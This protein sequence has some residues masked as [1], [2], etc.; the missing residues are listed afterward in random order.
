M[1]IPKLIK[2]GNKTILT[3]KDKT[4]VALAGEVHNSD[5]S[6]VEYMEGIWKIADDL[7]MNTLLLPVTWE[8]VEPV[9]GQYDFKIVED[10]I[11]QAR[12]WGKKIGFLW[13][14]SWKNAECMYTPEWVKTDLARFK[15][16]Q[17]EKGKNKAGRQISPSIPFKMPYTTISYLCTEA[18][19]ADAKVFTK[20]MEFI[21]SIDE[22]ENTVI[23]VQVENETGLLGAARENSDEAD[24]LFNGE[25]PAEFADYMHANSET[26]VDDVK[27]AVE[28]GAPRGTWT[29]VFG[30][31]AEEIFSAYYVST[32]VDYVAAAGKAVYPLPMSA[33][34]WLDKGGEP[35]S[36]PTGGPV[37]R[38]HEVWNFC[39]PNIDIYSPDI[40]VPDFMGV[41]NEFTRRETPL[42]IPEAA[43]HSYAA[44]RMVYTVGHYHCVCYSPFGFDDIGKP[45]TATQGYLFGMDVNDPALKTP[46]NY[47]EYGAAGK[48]LQQLMP[49][50]GAKLGTNDL[51]AACGEACE[52][53]KPGMMAFG[54]GFMAIANFKNQMQ[55]RNDGYVLIVKAGENEIYALGNA[56]SLMLMSADPTRPNCDILRLEEGS[57]DE[58]GKWVRGRILNGDEAAQLGFEKPSILRIKYFLYN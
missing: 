20:L 55:P 13:F 39:A 12:R 14:G 35:G 36:Y 18:M 44:P 46:Q 17:M 31:V 49:L 24:A 41:C 25:V 52:D 6:S 2:Q 50:I 28:S 5:S 33:N 7:G 30:P 51:Q 58:N 4:F 19:E 1:S 43:T 8:M 54:D 3:V 26:M 9:E 38:V 32:F 23:T 47:E 56:A 21:K 15:R 11:L 34:C 57:F 45:F 27:A 53:G 40:Y 42:Y 29:E 22:E 37:S 48:Y 16:A 10:L